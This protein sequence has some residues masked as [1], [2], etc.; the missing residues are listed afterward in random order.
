MSWVALRMLTGNRA[1]F[2]GIV[3]GVTFAA[4]LIAQQASIFCGPMLMTTSQIRDIQGAQIWV[5]DPN[6]QFIDDIKPMSEVEL[7]PRH[8]ARLGVGRVGPHDGAVPLAQGR[9]GE[10]EALG[11][12]VMR[13]AHQFR[14]SVMRVR[15]SVRLVQS[16]AGWS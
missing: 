13:D 6:V 4:L 5:M 15:K 8:I 7:F 1:K 11:A 14:N 9:I 3:L 16:T 2:M 10:V 12:A